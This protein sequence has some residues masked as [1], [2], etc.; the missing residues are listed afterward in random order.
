MKSVRSQAK[1]NKRDAIL[2][3]MLDVVV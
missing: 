2:N 3:A 1:P